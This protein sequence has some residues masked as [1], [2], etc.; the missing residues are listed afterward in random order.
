[1]P[2]WAL[3]ELAEHS[4]PPLCQGRG[5]QDT[6]RE[7]RLGGTVGPCCKKADS[8]GVHALPIAVAL[9]PHPTPPPTFFGLGRT[10]VDPTAWCDRQGSPTEKSGT[11]PGRTGKGGC[12]A[13]RPAKESS[14][15]TAGVLQSVACRALQ[16]KQAQWEQGKQGRGAQQGVKASQAEGHSRRLEFKEEKWEDCKWGQ[17]RGGGR[18]TA[19]EPMRSQPWGDPRRSHHSVGNG[20]CVAFAVR[21]RMYILN[22]HL[23]NKQ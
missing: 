2:K 7:A 4:A 8:R 13:Q 18:E 5:A 22:K 20:G 6:T 21:L 23:Y 3:D 11:S 12:Q 15:K 17:D 14:R 19:W 10:P 16:S 1:M 9:L